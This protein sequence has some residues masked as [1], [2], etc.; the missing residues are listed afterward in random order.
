MIRATFVLEQHIGHRTFAQNLHRFIAPRTDLQTNWVDVTYEQ[1]GTLWNVLPLPEKVR[2]PLNG[3][4]QIRTGLQQHPADVAI[5]NTQV[6]AALAGQ[7]ANQQPSFLCT[8]ITP[9]QYDEMAEHY[10]HAADADGWLSQYK[11]CLNQRLFQSATRLLPWSSWVADS[12]VADYG[13]DPAKITVLP[14][15]VDLNVWQSKPRTN[16]D[17]P[18]HILFVGGDF[19]RKGGETLLEAFNSLP[20]GTAVLHLVTRSKIP[21]TKN[22]FVYGNM[23]PNMPEL[24]TLYAEADVFVLPTR[25]EA[26]GI[27]AVEAAASGLPVIATRVGGLVDIVRDGETGFLL[28]P[29][30]TIGLRDKL[31]LLAQAPARRRQMGQAARQHAET[32]FN[33][34]RN[35]EKLVEMIVETAVG[36]KK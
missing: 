2:G 8:D 27:A 13:A 32:H 5:F 35:A 29:N 18:L 17:G 11:H 30:D 21:H 23:Q 19:Y 15:G 1:P 6:P 3:R 25:A 9:R 7:M 24:Q 28:P 14:P 34:R 26:F 4:T 36:A 16:H 12:L 20:T 33:A 22:V 31:C 10:H